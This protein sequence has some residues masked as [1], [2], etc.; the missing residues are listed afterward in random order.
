MYVKESR[1]QADLQ[2]KKTDKKRKY[3]NGM[4]KDGMMKE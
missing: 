3:S 4:M 1:K 2:H